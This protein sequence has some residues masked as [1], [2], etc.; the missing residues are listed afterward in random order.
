MLVFE[1]LEI[2]ADLR[3]C[4]ISQFNSLSIYTTKTLFPYDNEESL[5]SRYPSLFVEQFEEK[6]EKNE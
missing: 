2:L 3:F 5:D 4:A 1:I 6:S